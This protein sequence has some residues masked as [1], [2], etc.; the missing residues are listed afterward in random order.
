MDKN[1]K[2]LTRLQVQ[3]LEA[4]EKTKRRRTESLR[5]AN[6]V[7]E[8]VYAAQ[9][10]LNDYGKNNESKLLHAGYGDN[11]FVSFGTFVTGYF[12]GVSKSLYC[13]WA[14]NVRLY[15]QYSP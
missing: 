8:L 13:L 12:S 7:D 10:G 6:P 4:S 9:V 11:I 3:F 1:E 5:K 2:K 15:S 14:V